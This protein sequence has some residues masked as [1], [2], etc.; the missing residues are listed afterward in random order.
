MPLSTAADE[1]DDLDMRALRERRARPIGRLDDTA[2]KLHGDTGRVEIE[3]LEQLQNSVPVRHRMG[4]A[5]DHDLDG[6]VG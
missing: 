3:R 6:W 5:V 4:L 1:L 2:I